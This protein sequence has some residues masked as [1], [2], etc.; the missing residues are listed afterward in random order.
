[1]NNWN[2]EK[3]LAV[4]ASLDQAPLTDG[5][6]E[7]ATADYRI[8]RYPQHLLSPTLPAAQV[9]WSSTTR[10]LE[11]VHDE[12][13]S[14]VREWGL[15]ELHWWVTGTTQPLD[16]EPYLLARGG[17]LSGSSQ[18][19]ARELNATNTVDLEPNDIDVELVC[20]ERTLRGAEEVETRGWGRS[21]LDDDAMGCR[22][23]DVLANL[24]MATQF[25][26]VAFVD[27]LPA[28]TGCCRIQ[29][30]VARLYGAVTLPEFRLRGCYHAVLSTRL[31]QA[32]D[33]GATLALTRGRPLTSGPLLVKAG[34]TVHDEEHCYRLAVV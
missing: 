18:I 16:T 34:F 4:L 9:I 12:I 26:F 32:Q 13:V 11:V 27:G 33:L 2:T 24:K 31:R 15:G 23:A 5:L 3:I 17:V 19:L 7:F 25:Q 6:I 22:L 1:M 28:S 20:D 14:V 8:I 29:G 21:S 10:S 30:E